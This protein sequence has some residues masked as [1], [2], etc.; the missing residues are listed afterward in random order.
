[1]LHVIFCNINLTFFICFNVATRFALFGLC[2]K[3]EKTDHH[4]KAGALNT[5]VIYSFISRPI[6]MKISCILVISVISLNFLQKKSYFVELM[7]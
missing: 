6:F 5:L 4:K 2:I 3:R 7:I 1:M